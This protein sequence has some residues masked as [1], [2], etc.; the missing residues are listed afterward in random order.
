MLNLV[1]SAA[2]CVQNHDQ[3]YLR[4][5]SCKI[6]LIDTSDSPNFQHFSTVVSLVAS[7]HVPHLELHR[8]WEVHRLDATLH[9]AIGLL[10]VARLRLEGRVPWTG[11]QPD[12][13][14]PGEPG[15]PMT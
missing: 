7:P 4:S 10:R 3:P 11:T 5:P 15:D 6:D 1:A 9:K 13:G 2:Q 12:P 14:D 8:A